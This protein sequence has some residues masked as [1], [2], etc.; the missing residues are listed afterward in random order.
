MN[1]ILL[2]TDKGEYFGGEK[3]SGV[4]YLIIRSPTSGHGIKLKIRGYEKYWFEDIQSTSSGESAALERVKGHQEYVNCDFKLYQSTSGTIPRGQYMYPFQYPLPQEIPGTF[5]LSGCEP[6]KWSGLVEYYVTAEV[7]G[8]ES[9]KTTQ[10]LVIYQAVPDLNKIDDPDPVKVTCEVRRMF[11]L[12]KGLLTV[13]AKLNRSAYHAGETAVL[14]LG[15][16]NRTSKRINKITIKLI[17]DLNLAFKRPRSTSTVSNSSTAS[18]KSPQHGLLTFQPEGGTRTVWG[19][20]LEGRN[21]KL[22]EKGLSKVFIPLAVADN[23][24]NS[25]EIASTSNG[26]HIHCEYNVQVEVSV[27]AVPT[28]DL[29]VPVH[30]IYHPPNKEWAEWSPPDWVFSCK[31][32]LS[33]KQRMLTQESLNS[34][35]FAGIPGFQVLGEN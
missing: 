6:A 2:R 20:I 32:I 27:D 23:T 16:E 5:S 10:P 17:R 1:Q 11:G 31:C 24:L 9:I 12:L 13:S 19:K 26:E 8:A 35:S 21:P 25:N 3:V 18:A 4:V 14:N 28:L 33:E 7:I 15:V 34:E 30:C 29:K 22:L